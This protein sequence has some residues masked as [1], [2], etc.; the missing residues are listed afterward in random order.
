MDETG[1]TTLGGCTTREA[2]EPW[3]K[4]TCG[5]CSRF[6]EAF[7]SMREAPCFTLPQLETLCCA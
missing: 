3:S 6:S 4:P 7:T 1:T 2:Q 5:D